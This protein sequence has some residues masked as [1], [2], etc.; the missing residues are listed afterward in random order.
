VILSEEGE[1]GNLRSVGYVKF[2]AVLV[3]ALMVVLRSPAT[4]DDVAQRAGVETMSG[5]VMPFSMDATRHVFRPTLRGGT[6]AVV[7][8]DGDPHQAAL[9]RMHL[10][11]LT[12]MFAAGDFADP[13]AVHG[14]NMPG[15]KTLAASRGRL[16]VR[17]SDV[18]NGA[19][20]S[21]HSADATVVAALHRWFAAQVRDHGAHAVMHR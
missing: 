16:A 21:F 17:Y 8:I 5:V 4:A 10:R 18:P 1:A 6:Q 3:V 2:A 19:R 9:V 14:S 15:L 11:M 20:I 12:A 7:V 13:A